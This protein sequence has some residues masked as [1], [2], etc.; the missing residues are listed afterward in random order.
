MD[1]AD[2]FDLRLSIPNIQVPTQYADNSN[3]SNLVIDLI[4]LQANS[5]EI[6]NHSIWP[7]LHSPL[8]HVSLTVNIIIEK[9]L[10]QNKWRTIIKNSKEE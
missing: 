9:K 4:F 3:N 2:S 10:I 1:I 6:N 7:D 5:L 8:D